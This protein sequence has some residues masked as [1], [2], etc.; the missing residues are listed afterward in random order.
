MRQVRRRFGGLLALGALALST[1]CA[2]T[3]ESIGASGSA[4]TDLACARYNPTMQTAILEARVAGGGPGKTAVAGW[5]CGRQPF[6]TVRLVMLYY[7]PDDPDA[8]PFLVPVLFEEGALVAFGWHLLETQPER[9]GP[10]P[11]PSRDSPW[12]VPQGWSAQRA[13]DL[14]S[15]LR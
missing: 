3:T 1:A 5:M 4:F 11:L 13:R 8:P 7:T 6:G 2:G 9:Y 10:S 14:P 15:L 12:R